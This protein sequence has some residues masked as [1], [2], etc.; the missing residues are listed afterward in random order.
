MLFVSAVFLLSIVDSDSSCPLLTM[1]AMLEAYEMQLD[2]QVKDDILRTHN[3]SAVVIGQFD[4]LMDAKTRILN[5]SVPENVSRQIT[6][7]LVRGNYVQCSSSFIYTPNEAGNLGTG[8]KYRLSLQMVQEKVLMIYDVAG[9]KFNVA[10][11]V[12]FQEQETVQVVK[13]KKQGNMGNYTEQQIVRPMSISEKVLEAI[14]RRFY[15]EHA[16]EVKSQL[17]A[18]LHRVNIAINITAK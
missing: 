12:S 15:I 10:S 11:D 9:M 8:Y 1:R 5:Q 7:G 6:N 2:A 13:L 14:L 16:H 17:K 4:S 18:E 3:F